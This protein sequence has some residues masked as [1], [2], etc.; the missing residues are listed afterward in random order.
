MGTKIKYAFYVLVASLL[1]IPIVFMGGAEAEVSCYELSG[2]SVANLNTGAVTP[3]VSRPACL[4][5]DGTVSG[6]LI[7][8]N[9]GLIDMDGV[10]IDVAGAESNYA[11]WS[12]YGYAPLNAYDSE[13]IYGTYF[14]FS[15]VYTDLSDG[16]IGGLAHNANLGSLNMEGLSMELPELVLDVEVS[17][18]A[19]GNTYEGIPVADGVSGYYVYL[20]VTPEDSALILDSADLSLT[21]SLSADGY[22]YYDQINGTGASA[23]EAINRDADFSFY[24]ETVD[25]GL[26]YRMK[27]KSYAPTSDM[28]CTGM[29]VV[30]RCVDPGTE[31]SYGLVD[32]DLSGV[33]SRDFVWS[34]F[35]S[36]SITL[37]LG[38]S[39]SFAPPYN[40]TGLYPVGAESMGGVSL[41]E[42]GE[43]YHF[44][45][46]F[47]QYGAAAVPG[48]LNVYYTISDSDFDFGY[49]STE[50]TD[51]SLDVS[52]IAGAL[53]GNSAF[54]EI[55]V[56]TDGAGALDEGAAASVV[57]YIEATV[58][59]HAIAYPCEYYIFADLTAGIA[60]PRLGVIGTVSGLAEGDD[61]T[62]VG[63]VSRMELRDVVFEQ[64][65]KVIR[66]ISTTMSGGG[67]VNNSWDVASGGQSLVS[68]SVLYF[69]GG[70]GDVVTIDGGDISD[71]VKTILVV[72]ADVYVK[73][74]IYGDGAI[75]IIVLEDEGNGGN[76]YVDK[77]VVD[78]YANI[79]LDGTFYRGNSSGA[80]AD[81]D[82]ASLNNQLYIRGSV[83]S[84][85]TIGGYDSGV[86][87]DGSACGVV[88]AQKED[89]NYMSNYMACYPYSVDDDGV[90]TVDIGS[91]EECD[92]YSS[93]TRYTGDYE[94]SPIVI[95]YFPPSEDLPIFNVSGSV[96]R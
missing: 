23:R 40:L 33:M 31:N 86:C 1:F 84:Q 30:E 81:Y 43:T 89:L 79:F 80:Y 92:G 29:S 95:E 87:G 62:V 90:V 91:R 77:N 94:Y 24:G 54:D 27:I 36:D 49:A 8:D 88:D 13:S 3:D 93:S 44:D 70:A 53:G 5:D 12:G 2:T 61:V 35:E 58:G 20:T 63:D 65:V 11:Y 71:N 51:F 6:L 7:S 55:S 14:D 83:I 60:E 85:N 72:G 47:A 15:N 19:Y 39:L 96:T 42:E 18:E 75:G 28:L 17:Y 68:D 22:M 21:T 57:T 26:I 76:M 66:G 41:V 67:R 64:V 73:D 9:I 25:S 4:F 38:R 56:W 74:S 78:L 10:T 59:G 48:S 52:A 32:L 34:G 37:D 45:P 16:S 46:F 69:T 82:S 50:E